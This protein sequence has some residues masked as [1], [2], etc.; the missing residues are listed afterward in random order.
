MLFN[1]KD[2]RETQ[3]RELRENDSSPIAPLTDWL[4]SSLVGDCA[5]YYDKVIFHAE[6]A[7]IAAYANDLHNYWEF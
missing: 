2:Y 4:R 6:N 7:F 5:H 1:G 3:L